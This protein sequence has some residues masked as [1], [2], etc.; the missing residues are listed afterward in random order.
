MHPPKRLDSFNDVWFAEV[1]GLVK[2]S[3]IAGSQR[4]RL[5]GINA[6]NKKKLFPHLF[7]DARKTGNIIAQSV[8]IMGRAGTYN[9]DEFFGFAAQNRF[10]LA[11]SFL[12]DRFYRR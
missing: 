12:F 8:F 2:H 7:I 4:S 9:D 3:F 10:Q 5:I 1:I 11:V 6:R